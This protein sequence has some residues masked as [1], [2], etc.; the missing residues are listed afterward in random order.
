MKMNTSKM[1]MV[2]VAA[3]VFSMLAFSVQ[4]TMVTNGSF[5]VIG[6][7]PAEILNT[8]LPGWSI[9]G[10][11]FLSCVLSS[12]TA[13]TDACG[14]TG[15]SAGAKLWLDPGPSPDGGNFVLIDGDPAVSQ[16]LSQTLNGL[17]VGQLYDVS[18]FQAAGQFQSFT[19]AT[20]ERWLVTLGGAPGQLSERM[21][22][23]SHSFVS[24]ESQTLRFQ[25]PGL[26]AGDITSEVL[27]FFA[28]GTA[29]NGG[30]PAGLPPVVLL[31]GVSITA[32]PEPETYALLGVGL[33]G[34][35]FARRQQKKRA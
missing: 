27:G 24:W 14:S 7:V 12:T 15:Q 16:T 3:L 20:T 25:V 22:N 18:F 29:A 17:V 31:D 10:S 1:A 35:L 33:L 5:A 2:G 34:V 23:A 30:S 28:V 11:S 21:N 13:T 32:V 8:N 4:A 19:G 26:H 6:P 9:S